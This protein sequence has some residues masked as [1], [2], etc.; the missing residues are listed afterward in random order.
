MLS[1]KSSSSI[2][3]QSISFKKLSYMV[4]QTPLNIFLDV[5]QPDSGFVETL[6]RSSLSTEM[7][8]LTAKIIFKLIETP[9]VEHINV[10]LNELRQISSYWDH[11]EVILKET[12]V[13]KQHASSSKNKKSLKVILHKNDEDLWQNILDLSYSIS[14]YVELPKQFI[15]NVLK[16]I[17][18]N[19]NVVLDLSQFEAKF[20]QLVKVKNQTKAKLDIYPR[21]NELKLYQKL[22]DYVKPNIVKGRF[23]SVAHYLDIHLTLLREDFISPLRDGICRIIEQI[24]C[25]P[26]V[27]PT[28]NPSVHYYPNVRIVRKQHFNSPSKLNV[29][30]EYL[31]VDLEVKFRSEKKN[32]DEINKAKY[33]KK[34]M[35]GSL[36][37]LSSSPY[38]EDMILA[39]VSNRD[40]N[41]LNLGFVSTY[42]AH[43]DI[44]SFDV[45]FFCCL[46]N[47]RLKSK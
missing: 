38:F 30:R 43:Y 8:L 47:S 7:I 39:V 22:S 12:T 45:I 24:H 9:F 3:S 6:N 31:M 32:S 4:E 41:L 16:I 35:Y 17:K 23:D 29:K 1:V 20:G 14:K 44:F 26:K 36:L 27:E 19:K 33:L 2:Y 10:L 37:C 15:E 5:F 40:N 42:S 21:L 28:S 25:D 13:R 46:N 18:G 34:L 11:I